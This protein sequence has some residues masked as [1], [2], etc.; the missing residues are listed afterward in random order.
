MTIQQTAT[1]LDNRNQRILGL[2]AELDKQIE[3]FKKNT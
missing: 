2:F 1:E 3:R